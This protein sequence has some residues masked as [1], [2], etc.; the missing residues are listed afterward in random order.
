MLSGLNV[1][2]RCDEELSHQQKKWKSR[3]SYDDDQQCK[4]R[5]SMIDFLS[6]W[7][8][9]QRGSEIKRWSILYPNCFITPL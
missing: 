5:S 7:F 3:H 4:S 6:L 8:S 2:R 1:Q 9:E